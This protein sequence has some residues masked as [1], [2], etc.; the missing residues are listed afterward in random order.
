MEQLEFSA[1]DF[2]NRAV[3]P[4]IELGA[5][6][7][8]WDRDSVSF[9]TIASQFAAAPGAVPSDF[10][11][12]KTAGTYANDVH[13]LLRDAGVAHYGVRV[14]G[15]GEYPDRLRD[16]DHPVEL[17]YYQGWW[18]LVNSPRSIAIVGTRNPSEEGIKRTRKLVRSLLGDDFTIVSGLAKGVDATAHSTAISEGGRTVGVLGT[19]LSH[20][21]PKE[22][23]ALQRE[24]AKNHLLISQV[25]VL[26]YDRQPN[27]TAHRHFFPA[28][29]ITMSALTD[30]TVIVEAGETSGTLVQARAAL[31]QGRQLFILDSCFQNSKL[32]WPHT[33]AER[34]AIRVRDYNDIRERLLPRTS[35]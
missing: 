35:H 16:A 29:N 3:S 2:A 20:S 9:K 31:K 32:T 17:L 34:G 11:D 19:P 6:E 23:A 7:A 18:E 30:A 27:P 10:V 24:I 21:Y 14:H 12:R 5:Y 28:R 1:L 33:F 15:A 25:P 26:R 4:F 13:R 22:N 8:L